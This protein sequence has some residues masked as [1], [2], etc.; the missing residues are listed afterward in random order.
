MNI[1]KRIGL[2][3]RLIMS[4]GVL[5]IFF[6]AVVL[7]GIK[8]LSDAGDA[9]ELL[10]LRY[11]Q[12]FALD[13]LKIMNTELTLLYMDIIIDKDEGD[14]SAERKEWLKAFKEELAG[15]EKR[16][17]AAADTEMERKNSAAIFENLGQMIKTG[18]EELIP[19]VMRK[20]EDPAFWVRMDDTLD[21]LGEKN[22]GLVDPVIAGIRA[23]V[24]KAKNE[25]LAAQ[26]SA[27]FNLI[28]FFA[29]GMV[30]SIASIIVILSSILKPLKV[31]IERTKDLSS[32]D[33]DMT[34]RIEID[35]RDE[36]GELGGWFNKFL[37]RLQVLI[38]KIKE[39]A[40]GLGDSTED[41]ARGSED[42][43]S[44]TNEQSASL[45]ETS[46]TVE[47]FS[48]ILKQNNENSEEASK[49]LLAFNEEIQTR[50]NL[51]T[52]V[53]VTMSEIDASSKKIDN[54]VNVINDISFQTN[55][56]ALN[57][58]VEAARAGEAGRGFAVVASE[59]R[60]LAQK[61]AESSKTIQEI[62][63]QNVESSQKGMEL[64][65]ETSKLFESIVNILQEMSDKLRQIARGSREQSTGVDQINQAILQL[66][67]V[68][69]QNAALVEELSAAGK[70]LKSGANEL[71]VLV[72]QFKVED[73]TSGTPAPK[74]AAPKKTAAKTPCPKTPKKKEKKVKTEDRPGTGT[75]DDFF[76]SDEGD[77]EE[78]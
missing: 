20:E 36:L 24:E 67:G 73:G 1:L 78:F 35:T 39:R 46:T 42:L 51:I 11:Q 12:I 14:V 56:L 69:N 61:T 31:M 22:A 70:T 19:A 45:T 15:N 16:V 43:A 77:F 55:L 50:K 74:K 37:D 57:A 48:V 33:V 9:E 47:Q 6:I 75:T 40:G 25:S 8:G 17:M 13:E 26:Q 29:V 59:V 76:A 58:A 71:V 30:I 23:E 68:V 38:V 62:V 72:D 49:T 41:I 27:R 28:I 18:D 53:T 65:T 52:D 2:G 4:S 7:V 3:K 21:G 66:E 63:T 64:I 60:N 32:G 10:E 34:R 44:R 54:I 5:V